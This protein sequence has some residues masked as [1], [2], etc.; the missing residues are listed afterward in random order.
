MVSENSVMDEKQAAAQLGVSV[1][2]LR[3]W[4]V[5]RDGG[6]V[7]LKI[8]RAVRYSTEDLDAFLQ[9]NRVQPTNGEEVRP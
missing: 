5:N 7:Y 4:R 3:K 8:G 9:A 2:L 1:S 6:P